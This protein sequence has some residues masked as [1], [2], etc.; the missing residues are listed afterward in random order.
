MSFRSGI[1]SRRRPVL[2]CLDAEEVAVASSLGCFF[3]AAVVPGPLLEDAKAEGANLAASP[4]GKVICL[5]I[6]FPE[7]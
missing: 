5:V 3:P 4:T 1:G 2:V 7:L 6:Y